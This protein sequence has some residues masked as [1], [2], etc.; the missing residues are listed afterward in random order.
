MHGS[1]WTF[2]GDPEKLRE[3]YDGIASEILP[4]MKLHLCLGTPDGIIFVDTC[5]DRDAFTRFVASDEFRALRER[6]GLPEPERIE[7]F[8]VHAAI[9]DGRRRDESA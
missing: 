6:H 5:P 9:V 4:A 1:I 2:R 3:A 8:P 7:D